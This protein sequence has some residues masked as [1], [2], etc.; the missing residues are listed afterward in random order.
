[1]KDLIGTA[2]AEIDYGEPAKVE[3]EGDTTRFLIP[4][5]KRMIELKQTESMWGQNK[6]YHIKFKRW[7]YYESK[8][9]ILHFMEDS[10]DDQEG[11]GPGIGRILLHIIL[12]VVLIGFC[13][14][15]TS[16][17]VMEPR[18]ATPVVYDKLPEEIYLL[19]E[20][21]ILKDKNVIIR[22]DEQ[23]KDS[24]AFKS[25]NITEDMVQENADVALY[26]EN[27][28]RIVYIGSNNIYLFIH[29]SEIGNKSTF[30]WVCW[31]IHQLYDKKSGTYYRIHSDT[32]EIRKILDSTMQ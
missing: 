16:Y 28:E 31:K 3:T 4:E 24:I 21:R 25:K 29:D 1:L 32:K 14:G 9:E 26:Y 12:S 2:L 20:D 7:I 8:R 5:S 17:M 15:L 22:I 23:L 13:A 10:L 27:R 18:E 30:Y 6:V 19:K 11:Y